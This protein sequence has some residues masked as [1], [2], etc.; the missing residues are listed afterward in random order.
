MGR[1]SLSVKYNTHTTHVCTNTMTNPISILYEFSQ[2]RR[3]SVPKFTE[4]RDGGVDHLPNWTVVCEVTFEGVDIS[5]SGIAGDIQEAKKRA[6]EKVLA[7]LK[8]HEVD[9]ATRLFKKCDL[10]KKS[11]T[12]SE[13]PRHPRVKREAETPTRLE[14]LSENE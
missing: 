12:S 1:C 7:E 13:V 3:I 4:L 9:G 8:K 10:N 6:A 2:K 5:E 11:E 14:L